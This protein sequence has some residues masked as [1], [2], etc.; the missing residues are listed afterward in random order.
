MVNNTGNL[1]T[2]EQFLDELV[3]VYDQPN[4][5][6][7]SGEVA[8]PT[9]KTRTGPDGPLL[10]LTG[11]EPIIDIRDQDAEAKEVARAAL[12]AAAAPKETGV[13]AAPAK[14]K[15]TPWKYRGGLTEFRQEVAEQDEQTEEVV[16]PETQEMHQEEASLFSLGESVEASRKNQNRGLRGWLSKRWE[17]LTSWSPAKKAILAVGSVAIVGASLAFATS[18]IGGTSE[19]ETSTPKGKSDNVP[20]AVAVKKA[21]AKTATTSTTMTTPVQAQV[22][23]GGLET[24]PYAMTR[25][26]FNQTLQSKAFGDYVVYMSNPAHNEATLKRDVNTV[27]RQ[28]QAAHTSPV[29]DVL[30]NAG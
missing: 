9:T 19:A 17:Q 26:E 6:W 13:V 8:A 2:P 22:H 16:E 25:E 10:D 14:K 3:E 7:L 27:W 23:V 20:E 4:L 29:L 21:A 5:Q 12:L 28:Q 15:R 18:A 1:N 11:D 24:E 30:Q